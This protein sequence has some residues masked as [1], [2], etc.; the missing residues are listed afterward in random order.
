MFTYLVTYYA[1]VHWSAQATQCER[2]I[3]CKGKYEA[4]V[5]QALKEDLIRS[6]SD[7]TFCSLISYAIIPAA[8]IPLTKIPEN[9]ISCPCYA[10]L[11]HTHKCR[12]L[13]KDVNKSYNFSPYLERPD[14]CPIRVNKNL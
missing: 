1:T 14:W 2:K 4:D 12:S 8:Y 7:Q 5:I 10:Y 13:D 6:N 9:C 3:S 11:Y